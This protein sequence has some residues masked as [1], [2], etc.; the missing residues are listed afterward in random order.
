MTVK[1]INIS[2]DEREFLNALK[3]KGDRTWKEV[4]M[5]GLGKEGKQE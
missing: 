3:K 4:L 1:T 5:D 2:L